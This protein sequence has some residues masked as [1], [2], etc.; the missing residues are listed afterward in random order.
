MADKSFFFLRQNKASLCNTWF[1]FENLGLKVSTT[2][3]VYVCEALVM[4]ISWKKSAFAG[5]FGPYLHAKKNVICL[6]SYQVTV[7]STGTEPASNR[8]PLCAKEPQFGLTS[9]GER[10]AGSRNVKDKTFD[11]CIDLADWL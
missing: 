1:A 11:G 6:I 4:D 2:L 8:Q 5:F 3:K 10:I 7:K 9:S